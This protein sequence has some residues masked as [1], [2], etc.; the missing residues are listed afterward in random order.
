[1]FSYLSW[2]L[3]KLHKQMLANQEE[4]QCHSI[5]TWGNVG[6]KHSGDANVQV[7]EQPSSAFTFTVGEMEVKL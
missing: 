4:S 7:N 6:Y 5:E 2:G 3:E 1:M